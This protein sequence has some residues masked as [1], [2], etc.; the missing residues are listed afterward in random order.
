MGGHLVGVIIGS[1]IWAIS[2]GTIDKHGT[3]GSEALIFAAALAV[4]IAILMMAV[5]NTEHPPAAGTA[6]GLVTVGS[7]F[8]AAGFILSAAAILTVIRILLLKRLTNLL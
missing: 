7:S 1:A 2:N 6:L 4:G 8:E 3:F 5:T